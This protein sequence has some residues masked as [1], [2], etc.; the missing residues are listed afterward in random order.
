MNANNYVR[1]KSLPRPFCKWWK[2][3]RDRK[4]QI[5]Q[6]GAFI[7]PCIELYVPWWG[8]PFELLHRLIFGNPKMTAI[9]GTADGQT[10]LVHLN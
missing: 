4:G 3:V 5:P 6:K 2:R 10:R 9:E 1:G 7:Q 8:W